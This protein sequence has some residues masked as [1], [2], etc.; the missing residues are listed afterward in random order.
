MNYLPADI[1]N[2]IFRITH[3]MQFIE[4]KQELIEYTTI[5]NYIGGKNLKFVPNSIYKDIIKWVHNNNINSLSDKMN[6]IEDMF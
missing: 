6:F 1:I 3:E 5:Y 4:V 2:V